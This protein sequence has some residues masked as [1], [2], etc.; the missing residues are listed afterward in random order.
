MASAVQR[1]WWIFLVRNKVVGHQSLGQSAAE[2]HR[3]AGI[4]ILEL[5]EFVQ[6]AQHLLKGTQSFDNL[7]N[8]LRDNNSFKPNPLRGLA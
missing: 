6:D 1:I 4:T 7:V 8:D 3:L 5:E 2:V